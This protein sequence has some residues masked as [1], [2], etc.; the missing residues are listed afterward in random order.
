MKTTIKLFLATF[1]LTRLTAMIC[2]AACLSLTA[3]AEAGQTV[4]PGEAPSAAFTQQQKI[5]VAAGTARAGT[6]S[7]GVAATAT[8]TASGGATTGAAG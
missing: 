4:S 6:T 8:T 7:A 2:A 1:S 5:A 3:L